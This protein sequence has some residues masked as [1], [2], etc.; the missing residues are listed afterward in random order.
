MKWEKLMI[1]VMVSGSTLLGGRSVTVLAARRSTPRATPVVRVASRTSRKKTVKRVVT[2]PS[3][4]RTVATSRK[5]GSKAPA[6][7]ASTPTKATSPRTTTATPTKSRVTPVTK[8]TVSKSV[9][10]KRQPTKSTRKSVKKTRR[11]TRSTGVKYLSL[12]GRGSYTKPHIHFKPT[13]DYVRTRGI[14]NEP[15]TIK[16]TRGYLDH[17][18]FKTALYLPQSLDGRDLSTPQ[19][20]AFSANNRYL[21]VMYV[22]GKQATNRY[23]DGWAVRYDWDKLTALGA[24]RAGQMAMLRTAARDQA[25]GRLTKMDREVLACIK[26][27]PKFNSGHAQSLAFNPKTNQFWFVKA[28]DDETPNVMMRLNPKTLLPDA[29]VSYRST[30]ANLGGVLTFD[31]QG[32]AYYWTHAKVATK[33]TPLGA[34]KLYRGTVTANGIHYRVI[35][36]GLATDPGFYAQSMGYDGANDRLYLV[37]D[38]SI[39]SLLLA[40]LGHLKASQVGENNF[41]A[42]REFEG[43]FFMHNSGDGFLLTN[44][45]T[46]IMRMVKS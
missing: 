43:L 24:D 35:P 41:G 12:V 7:S 46:E 21:Y 36:Q 2:R 31:N 22:N 17:Y 38:E 20:A 26:V 8:R 42:H 44:R 34:V 13:A 39:T 11:T 29:T 4:K 16:S 40:D 5:K 28:Y 14:Q 27:G 3:V 30:G 19:S 25:R 23:Q 32:Y 10:T 15:S 1:G 33:T 9:K 6:V 37:S 45:G 18:S